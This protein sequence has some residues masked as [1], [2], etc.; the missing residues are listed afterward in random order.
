MRGDVGD[1]AEKTIIQGEAFST[2]GHGEAVH[3]VEA[4]HAGKAA[5][6]G[7]A[8]R[9]EVP[10]RAETL[11]EARPGPCAARSRSGN[12]EARC[13]LHARA[14]GARRDPGA[15][16]KRSDQQGSREAPGYQRADAPPLEE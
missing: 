7:E 13:I 16:G 15:A 11:T 12:P 8:T 10:P 9:P 5:D 4:V 3:A 2:E 1:T 6:T 14:E